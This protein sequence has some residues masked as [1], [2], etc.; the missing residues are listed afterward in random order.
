L[1]RLKPLLSWRLA[2]RHHPDQDKF[3]GVERDLR[4]HSSLVAELKTLS[5]QLL[6]PMATATV[7]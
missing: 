2:V 4:F 6:S 5:R 7:I 1:A 3:V